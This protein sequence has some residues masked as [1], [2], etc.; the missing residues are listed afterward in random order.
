MNYLECK[1]EFIHTICL[2]EEVKHE[3]GLTICEQPKAGF[4]DAI[5]LA[6]GHNEFKEL[7]ADKIHAFGKG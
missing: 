5:V 4:Y 6:V 2:Q 1:C 7:G 3:Y